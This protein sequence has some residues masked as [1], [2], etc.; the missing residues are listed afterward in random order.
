MASVAYFLAK[1]RKMEETSIVHIRFRIFH[2]SQSV[3]NPALTS[4]HHPQRVSDSRNIRTAA[5]KSGFIR[6]PVT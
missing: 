5:S 1:L 4:H 2:G 6:E 3:W